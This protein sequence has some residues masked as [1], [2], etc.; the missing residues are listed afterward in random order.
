MHKP[1][2]FPALPF[3]GEKLLFLACWYSFVPALITTSVELMDYVFSWAR[4]NISFPV[5]PS[6]KIEW[7]CI[8][9]NMQKPLN[10]SYLDPSW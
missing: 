5:L 9:P 4:T 7:K 8:S 10:L 6:W 2:P 3:L 1:F